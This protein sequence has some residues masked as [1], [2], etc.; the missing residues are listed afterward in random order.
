MTLSKDSYDWRIEAGYSLRWDF[1]D[2]R[3]FGPGLGRFL[4]DPASLLQ[5]RTLDIAQNARLMLYGVR[6]SPWKLLVEER[7]RSVPPGSAGPAAQAQSRPSEATRRRLRLSLGP[8]IEDIRSNI[9][10]DIGHMVLKGTFDRLH[11]DARRLTDQDRETVVR[12]VLDIPYLALPDDEFES[13]MG[14]R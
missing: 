12:D 11:P 14:R 6:I 2:L 3:D 4:R 10:R 8:F 7:R 1:G 9:R 5:N 13:L